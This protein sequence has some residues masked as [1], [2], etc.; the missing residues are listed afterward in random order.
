M[1]D[2]ISTQ[3][4]MVSDPC[5]CVLVHVAC[6]V[7]KPVWRFQPASPG[8][9]RTH[10]PIEWGRK[11]ACDR[12]STSTSAHRPRSSSSISASRAAGVRLRADASSASACRLGNASAP[13]SAAGSA[14]NWVHQTL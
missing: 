11:R 14:F 3:M 5:V 4:T 6:S 12:G 13:S 8:R 7:R 2:D 1:I 9:K 10:A